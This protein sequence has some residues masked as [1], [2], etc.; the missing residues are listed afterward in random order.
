MRQ[1]TGKPTDPEAPAADK[2]A[3]NF[4]NGAVQL[5]AADWAQVKSK[6]AKY[7]ALLA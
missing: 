5:T 1:Y 4:K 2:Y 3:I 6:N 7:A